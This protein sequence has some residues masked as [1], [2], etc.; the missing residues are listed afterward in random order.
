MKLTAV[1]GGKGQLVALVHAHLSE[2]NRDRSFTN[3]PHATLQP[4]PGQSFHEMTAPQGHEKL[5]PAE[6]RRWVMTQI[7][8]RRN[9]R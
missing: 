1:V 7:P 3:G 9:K 8:T 5:S 2:H 6:L 4:Q